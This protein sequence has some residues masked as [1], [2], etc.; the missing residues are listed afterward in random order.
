[1]NSHQRRKFAKALIADLRN[2]TEDEKL[3]ELIEV[4]AALAKQGREL[5]ARELEVDDLQLELREAGDKHTL[6]RCRVEQLENVLRSVLP[7]L[8][9]YG[10][11]SE[12]NVAN[13]AIARIEDVLGGEQRC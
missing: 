9:Q 1:M 4:C 12:F 8:H 2:A 13:E 3:K 5:M 7:A 10:K 6:L 11:Y